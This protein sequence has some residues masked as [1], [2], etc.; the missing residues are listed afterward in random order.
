VTARGFF[1]LGLI[2][3]CGG[4]TGLRDTPVEGG[5]VGIDAS[6]K[7]VGGHDV[8]TIDSGGVCSYVD[9]PSPSAVQSY[10]ACGEGVNIAAPPSNN[11][12]GGGAAFEYVPETDITIERIELHTEA[13]TVGLLDSDP[14]CDLPG[15]VLFIAQTDT[16]GATP[17]WRGAFVNPVIGVKA[18]H[19]YFVYQA[20]A[21]GH[22]STACSIADN[23]VQVREYTAPGPNGPWGG[24]FGGLAWSARLDGVCP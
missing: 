16:Q 7:D 18:G 4:R 10:G 12:A 23:G 6:A 21:Q 13:A 15:K 17:D 2:A 19:K 9:D 22:G 1:A 8:V 14:A 3:A 20:P 11:C 5:V 24:P